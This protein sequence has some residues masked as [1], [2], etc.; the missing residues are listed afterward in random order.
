LLRRKQEL[1]EKEKD[2]LESLAR[3]QEEYERGKKEIMEALAESIV[4]VEKD[5]VQATRMAELLGE[6]RSRFQDALVELS[7]IDENK[8]AEA[9]FVVELN[10]AL[11]LVR[12]TQAVYRKAIARIEAA[13][14][15]K[16]AAHAAA[17]HQA[18]LQADGHRTG[19]GYWFKVGL[20]VTLPAIVAGVVLFVAWLFLTGMGMI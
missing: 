8:W 19:F 17:G 15:H 10:R 12:N 3:K 6:T 9:G 14:W 2:N 18:L 11:A 16:L 13:G 20:A 4:S 7:G 5:E 1:L